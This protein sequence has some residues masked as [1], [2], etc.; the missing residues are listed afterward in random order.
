M[1][2]GERAAIVEMRTIAARRAKRAKDEARD[3]SRLRAM[4]RTWRGKINTDEM[5]KASGVKSV[6]VRKQWYQ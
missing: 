1:P 5:A 3:H 2:N 4:W 6:T